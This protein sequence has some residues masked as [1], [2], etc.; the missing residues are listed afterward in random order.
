L[1]IHPLL[2]ECRDRHSGSLI[3]YLHE[4]IST[5]GPLNNERVTEAARKLDQKL[6]NNQIQRLCGISKATFYRY[7]RE[8]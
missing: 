6:E 2:V 8:S 1:A 4:A 3:G 7:L 5:D